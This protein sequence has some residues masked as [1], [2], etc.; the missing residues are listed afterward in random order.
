MGC[1]VSIDD[2]GTGFSSLSYLGKLPVDELKID[3]SFIMD[4]PD[5]AHSC[6]IAS[7]IIFLSKNFKLLTVAEGIETEQQHNFLRKLK[8]DQFQGF[9]F[10]RPVPPAQ[11]AQALGGGDGKS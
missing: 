6:A 10:S 9:L 1:K 5:N 4:I 2:F 11:W 3:R 8:C 7:T